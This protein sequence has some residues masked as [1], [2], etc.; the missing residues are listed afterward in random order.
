[1]GVSNAREEL[2]ECLAPLFTSGGTNQKSLPSHH[3]YLTAHK[4]CLHGTRVRQSL[5]SVA[6]VMKAAE[7]HADSQGNF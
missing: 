7:G 5:G 3:S 6:F 2:P 1:M 4:K